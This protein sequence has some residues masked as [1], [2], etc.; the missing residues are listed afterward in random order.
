MVITIC[1]FFVL[2]AVA[3][4][5]LPAIFSDHMV[6]QQ[7]TKVAV[8]GW[9]DAGEEITI[10]ESWSGSSLKTK[11]DAL[12]NW[13][14][15]LQTLSAG[16]PY[17]LTLDGAN[18]IELK[19]VLLGEVW[20]CSG[21][22]NMVYALKSSSGAQEEIKKANQPS[23]R[24]FNVKRQYGS[25]EYVDAPGSIWQN[26]TT[27]TAPS[28]SAVAYYFSKKIH[29][30]LNVPVGIIY[31]A[32]GGTPAEAWTPKIVLQQDASLSVYIDRWKYIMD[33]AKKDSVSY[34]NALT[35]WE[36]KN[37]SGNTT[38]KP[39]EPQTFFYYKR[40]WREPGVL[41]NGM[42]RPVIPFKIKGF[43]WF[44]GESNVAYADEYFYL[45]STMIK[46]WRSHW[47]NGGN[48]DEPAFYF[49]QLAPFAYN[50]MDAAARLREAQHKVMKQV[51][52]TGM[53]VTVDVGDMKN[54]H[55]SRKK[56]VGERLAFIALN[57]LYGFE[58]IISTGP[59]L[60]EAV[61]INGKV[62]LTFDQKLI[63]PHNQKPAGI[64]IGYKDSVKDSL[65]FV[66]ADVQIK[67]NTLIALHNQVKKP[68]I[69]RYAWLAISEANLFNY[70]GLPAFPFSEI[71][72][73][74][75]DA[76]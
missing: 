14:V 23:I 73:H 57:K 42:I 29:Q 4:I 37:S 69:I 9:A 49:A 54:Q 55:F 41:F 3:T 15:Q 11:A 48:A 51:P 5:K 46:S 39:T 63:T 32:W 8:W 6:L 13:K 28:F 58:N 59:A 64:E 27:E 66:K 24:F 22:S 62:Y 19:D 26:T 71:I 1:A 7:K 16:G 60:K 40:P 53:A 47:Q 76:K 67:N 61:S 65:V 38:K 2:D 31:A 34:H 70:A 43:L 52:N 10:Y 50:D 35:E 17:T 18:K 21:Q 72:K 45:K 56:E 33:N 36:K 44:Q 68:V 74:K 12:G 75:N 25:D 20:L 30:Q